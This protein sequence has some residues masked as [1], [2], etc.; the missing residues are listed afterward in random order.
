MNSSQV[1]LT[2]L[3]SQISQ[4]KPKAKE[5]TRK[6]AALLTNREN[7]NDEIKRLQSDMNES[8]FIEENEDGLYE[9]QRSAQNKFDLLAQVHQ[10][11]YIRIFDT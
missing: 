10:Y 1:K 3:V 8:N 6:N 4:N 2:Q 5:A 7:M 11:I 9:Q